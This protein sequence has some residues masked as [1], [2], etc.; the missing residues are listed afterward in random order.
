MFQKSK[1]DPYL[2]G[3]RPSDIVATEDFSERC[4]NLM[5]EQHMIDLLLD[6]CEGDLDIVEEYKGFENRVEAFKSNV[7]LDPNSSVHIYEIDIEEITAFLSNK[8]Y[9][10]DEQPKELVNIFIKGMYKVL[11]EFFIQILLQIDFFWKID[12]SNNHSIKH[13]KITPFYDPDHKLQNLNNDCLLLFISYAESEPKDDGKCNIRLTRC[14]T[15]KILQNPIH[16]FSEIP[17]FESILQRITELNNSIYSKYVEVNTEVSI[18][19]GV[20]SIFVFGKIGQFLKKFN[21]KRQ[22]ANQSLTMRY[23]EKLARNSPES[24]QDLAWVKQGGNLQ[25]QLIIQQQQQK[26]SYFV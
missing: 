16:H 13:I 2:V 23:K 25:D 22:K 1:S 20:S 11:D 7:L 3:F 26:D 9:K 10:L 14:P 8:G 24:Q 5:D 19:K 12:K 18:Y 6:Y 17:I 4:V 15:A 21:S